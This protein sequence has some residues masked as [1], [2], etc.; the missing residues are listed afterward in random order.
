MSK[1]LCLTQGVLLRGEG[2]VC[3]CS[4]ARA[5][6]EHG[7]LAKCRRD[8]PGMSSITQTDPQCNRVEHQP[9][10]EAFAVVIRASP[11]RTENRVREYARSGGRAVTHL[12]SQPGQHLDSCRVHTPAVCNG[13]EPKRAKDAVGFEPT[14]A[15]AQR[16]CNPLDLCRIALKAKN[17]RRA[18]PHRV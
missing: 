18:T 10:A 11:D 1:N 6:V 2:R 13:L 4:P 15:F 17:L 3:G 9:P 12:E 7:R 5:G 14:M 16:I 8:L